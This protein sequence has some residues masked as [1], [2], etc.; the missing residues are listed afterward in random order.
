MKT[1]L[2]LYSQKRSDIFNEDLLNNHVDFLKQLYLNNQLSMCGPFVDNKGAVLVVMAPSITNAEE[3]INQ[4]PFI[5]QKYYEQ[6]II[7]EFMP[8]NAENN[9][10]MDSV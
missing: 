1:F 2:V 9:W 3:I 6:Y 4:D 8:A 5:Q 10:L 7:H